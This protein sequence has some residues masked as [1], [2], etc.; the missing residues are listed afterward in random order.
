MFYRTNCPFS[1][2]TKPQFDI[3][4]KNNYHH[5]N[6]AQV[7]INSAE[8]LKETYQVTYTP[9]LI[10]IVNNSVIEYTGTSKR[11]KDIEEFVIKGY[12]ND[13]S[14]K[15]MPIPKRM[16]MI[17][18]YLYYIKRD[19][20][21]YLVDLSKY[22]DDYFFKPLNLVMIPKLTRIYITGGAVV[23]SI[24]MSTLGIFVVCWRRGRTT[25]K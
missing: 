12:K 25:K 19:T 11:S 14:Y 8:L 17:Q 9:K 24:V 18:L 7:N 16:D 6:F 10:M 23:V 21:N 4:T 15:A 20:Y 13:T 22:S 5:T 3:V 1:Y 2:M